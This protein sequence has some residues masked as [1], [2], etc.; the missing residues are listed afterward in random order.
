LA[1]R[2]S[3]EIASRLAGSA[4][5]SKTGNGKIDMVD[6]FLRKTSHRGL[7]LTQ[8]SLTDRFMN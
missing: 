1:Y 6:A 7:E 8:T 4:S 5:A 3:S 2:S